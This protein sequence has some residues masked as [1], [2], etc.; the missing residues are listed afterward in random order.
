L[1]NLLVLPGF[2]TWLGGNRLAG[3]CQ[4]ILAGTGLVLSVWYIAWFCREWFH[5]GQAP[6]E[7]YRYLWVA[8][9]GVGTFLVGWAWGLVVGLWLVRRAKHPPPISA[10]KRID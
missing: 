2:G 9:V 4:M 10:V 8:L 1:T 7:N 3:V 5:S 6:F